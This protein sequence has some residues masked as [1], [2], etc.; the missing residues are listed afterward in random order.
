VVVPPIAIVLAGA[1]HTTVRSL[2]M[3]TWSHKG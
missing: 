1:I 2:L 3:L